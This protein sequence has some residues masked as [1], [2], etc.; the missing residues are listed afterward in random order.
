MSD[1]GQNW[2]RLDLGLFKS[3]FS[4]F[5]LTRNCTQIWSEKSRNCPIWGQSHF[6]PKSCHPETGSM[7]RCHWLVLQAL[8][9]SMLYQQPITKLSS[10]Y[11]PEI[12]LPWFT[13]DPNLTLRKIAIWMSVNCQKLDIFFKKIANEKNENFWHFFFKVKFLAIFWQSNGNFPEGQVKIQCECI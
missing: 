7:S 5:W 11:Q 4:K 1:L 13:Q 8:A 10:D 2:V 12:R 9:N 3:D 6:G